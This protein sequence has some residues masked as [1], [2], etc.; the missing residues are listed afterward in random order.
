MITDSECIQMVRDALRHLYDSSA[1]GASPL[2]DW[3]APQTSGLSRVRRLRQKL[4]NA[5]E[6]LR[7]GAEQPNGCP[8]ARAYRILDLR[9]I[10]GL[11]PDEAMAQLALQKS[12]FYEDHARAIRLA[13][14][15]LA[16]SVAFMPQRSRRDSD[17]AISRAGLV[18]QETARLMDQDDLEAV[19]LGEVVNELVPLVIPLARERCVALA[20]SASKGT[21]IE[22]A[23]RVLVRHTIIGIISE[24]ITRCQEGS[25]AVSVCEATDGQSV[26]IA[27]TAAEVSKRVPDISDEL[28]ANW[29][30]AMEA[31]AGRLGLQ[32][33]GPRELTAQLTWEGTPSETRTL[34]V[35]DDNQEFASLY[36]RYLVGHGWTVVGAT[37]TEDA[38]LAASDHSPAAIV[39]DLL[40]PHQDGWEVLMTLK[41]DPRTAAI[42]VIVCSVLDAGDLARSLGVAA[43]LTKPVDEAALVGALANA[44]S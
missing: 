23:S 6:S 24:M 17:D 18:Q 10:Q 41:H 11:T 8:D 32:R 1:L 43:C 2:L 42:P 4:L 12:Q 25:I 22:R 28:L 27:G 36:G 13:A 40:M 31:M 38:L 9:Y 7:P 44:V 16:S 29:Q 34:L 33:M 21:V 19:D 30:Q 37:G 3:I 15:C 26:R 20:I 14:E 39:L 5:I 35:I